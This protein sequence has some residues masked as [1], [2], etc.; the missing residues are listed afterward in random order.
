MGMEDKKPEE[1][2]E[3]NILSQEEYDKKLHEIQAQDELSRSVIA[4]YDG[5]KKTRRPMTDEE[6]RTLFLKAAD[7]KSKNMTKEMFEQ[8][9][10]EEDAKKLYP[11]CKDLTQNKN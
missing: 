8:H 7:F 4:P 5:S 10:I 3:I 9:K 11:N 6:M 2:K 1:K